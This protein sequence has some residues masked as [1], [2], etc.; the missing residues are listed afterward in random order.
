LSRTIGVAIHRRAASLAALESGREGARLLFHHTQARAAG[1]DPAAILSELLKVL[2]AEYCK[3]PLHVA[4]SPADLSCWDS[5]PAEGSSRPASLARV[6]PALC[7]ARGT[8]ETLETLA[9]DA[10]ADGRI[11]RSLSLDRALLDRLVAAA[12][13]PVELV[14]SIPDALASCWDATT[15]TFGGETV[16]ISRESRRA[17]PVDVAD[18]QD[19]RTWR[20]IDLAPS[21]AAAVAAAAAGVE[22][23]PN[24]V[25][26]LRG[27]RGLLL[28]RLRDPLLNVAAA[29]TICL[30]ALAVHFHREAERER[31]EIAE[32]NAKEMELWDRFLPA[33][34]PREGRLLRAMKDRLADLGQGSDAAE[35]PSALAFWGEIGRQMPD[36]DAIGLTLE[37]LDLAPDGG[38]I[39]ARV[40]VSPEDPIRNATQL[41]GKLNQ[42]KKMT[43]R[44]DYEVRDGQV[45]VRLRMNY[46]P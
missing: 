9:V 33:E 4:L 12:G 25:N 42:S 2:P 46:R 29:V 31:G 26:V 18:A 3:D 1:S 16:E 40:P 32:A 44:G 13:R 11:V 24:A 10:I 36:P 41:E 27:A 28:R 7:E 43:A 34:V 39:S 15:L 21:L 37:A 20:G 30:A 22:G 19:V 45:Q 8:G 14:T 23:V 5:W 35:I 17:Y 38:R 6:A